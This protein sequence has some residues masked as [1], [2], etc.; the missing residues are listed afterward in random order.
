MNRA[1][2]GADKV[3]SVRTPAKVNLML[4][5]HGLQ[6]DG[7]HELTS[8]V[9]PLGFADKLTVE[10]LE[11]GPDQLSCSMP[12]IPVDSSNLVLQAAEVFRAARQDGRYYQ[13]HLEKVVPA[14]AGLGGGSSNA[15]GALVAM[16][17]LG[18]DPLDVGAL[19]EL[20]AGLGSDCPFFI[21]AQICLMRGR[22]DRLEAAPEALV[23]SLRGQ[24]LVLFKPGFGINTAWA[25]GALKSASPEA[26]TSPS[27]AEAALAGDIE[28][29][30]LN[31][32]EGVIGYKYRSIKVL[33]DD[34]RTRGV[35]CGMSG[36]GSCCFALP[37][38]SSLKQ[39]DLKLIIESAWGDSVF[40]IETALD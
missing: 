1:K 12:G 8:L 2:K 40:F 27:V 22:G 7:F 19:R 4:A 29:L 17:Q 20:A 28:G 23:A 32:F 35:V 9:A 10:V 13:F 5:V 14:G 33:L 3:V 24:P 34:L 26:Y 30:V 21:E 11:S 25:Y 38:L 18:G 16:N 39:K 37:H 6:T 15:A 36:S 31:S